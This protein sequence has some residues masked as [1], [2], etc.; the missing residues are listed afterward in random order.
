MTPTETMLW[1]MLRNRKFK[2][3]KFRRQVNIGPYIVDFLCKQHRLIIEIDGKIHDY[4]K[5]YDQERDAYLQEHGYRVLRVTNREVIQNIDDVLQQIYNAI[6]LRQGSP[7]PVNRKKAPLLTTCCS[8]K[9]SNQLVCTTKQ[10]RGL[11]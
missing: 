2:G 3:L 1:E 7:S 8:K 10:E 11:G 4:Q 9:A 5:E 6:F